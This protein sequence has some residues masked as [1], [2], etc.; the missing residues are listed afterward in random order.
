MISEEFYKYLLTNNITTAIV[1]VALLALS[2]IYIIIIERKR[3]KAEINLAE[4][5]RNSAKEKEEWKLDNLLNNM[6]GFI[7]NTLSTTN[8]SHYAKNDKKVGKSYSPSIE[9]ILKLRHITSLNTMAVSEWKKYCNG[10][11]NELIKDLNERESVHIVCNQII[12]QAIKSTP[13]CKYKKEYEANKFDMEN[14]KIIP[15][16]AIVEKNTSVLA[17]GT[18]DSTLVPIEYK[19]EKDSELTRA[20]HQ[21]LGY[22]M[23]RLRDRLE[24]VEDPMTADIWGFCL[25][26]NGINLALG[27]ISVTN[28]ELT[29]TSF[30]ERGNEI[31][32]W[33]I[34]SS[35]KR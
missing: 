21:S 1:L 4:E 9:S 27:Y 34:S 25:G 2:L 23:R 28:G 11:K 22:L 29:V 13:D 32:F 14:I 15:D 10:V 3:M 8:A 24:I 6:D 5:R 30:G 33:C 31:P 16:V 12:D 17:L 26:I 35:P 18:I 7:A 19:K 20:I